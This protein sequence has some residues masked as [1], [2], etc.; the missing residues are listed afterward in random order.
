LASLALTIA[1]LSGTA[2][3]TAATVRTSS[4]S[5]STA[6]IAGSDMADEEGWGDEGDEL[7][8]AEIGDDPPPSA[9]DSPSHWS[10]SGFARSDLGFWAERFSNN[11]FAKGRQ[12]IDLQLRYKEDGLRLVVSTHG[13]Y[14]FAYLHRIDSYDDPTLDAYNH[15]LDVRESFG[16]LSV[17]P[18][19]LTV[20]WQIV[21]WGEGDAL[22]PLD[23]VNPRDLREPGLADLDDLRLPI[24]SSR[25]G[26]FFGYHRLEAMV[27]HEAFFG[28]R[29]PPF[30]PFSAIPVLLE[31]SSDP[32]AE[33]LTGALE[34][35]SLR[36]EDRPRRYS[37]HQQ[38]LFRWLYRGP[39][40]DLGLYAASVLDRQGAIALPS[41]FE[42][43]ISESP[44]LRLN[45]ERY[46]M[47]GHSGAKPFGSFLFKWEL[48]A[49]TDR[50]FNVLPQGASF[51]DLD[52]EEAATVGGMLGLSYSGFS[53][54]MLAVEVEHHRLLDD[55]PGLLLDFE[56][57]AIAF[58]FRRTFLR[59]DLVLNLAISFQGWTANLGWLGRAEASYVLRDG[60]K[61]GLG[62][63]TYQPVEEEFGFFSGLDRHDRVQAQLRWDF[64]A[65]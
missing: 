36:Y 17:G 1:L 12:S 54:T 27:I 38:L 48:Y 8:F 22:S 7:G 43:F 47:A 39:G 25:A 21:A 24:L 2:T 18:L 45:H 61:I 64:V 11:P 56:Q 5:S 41:A 31:R 34:G 55:L 40:L 62:F 49:A 32:Q 65:F 19:E 15:L 59:E 28:Y 42:I 16:A 23:V 3:A 4:V 53:D 57:P 60:L 37:G 26:V 58:R 14:D 9:P 50:P 44:A 51:L 52:T 13:E 10:L 30:G 29:S 33:M 46:F 35:K 20:G 63:I 6:A